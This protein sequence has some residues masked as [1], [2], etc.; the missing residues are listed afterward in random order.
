MKWVDAI[1]WIIA[2]CGWFAAHV[3]SEARERRKDLKAQL[4]KLCDRL[5]SLEASAFSF[6]TKA[7]FDPVQARALIAQL[8]RTER[9]IGLVQILSADALQPHIIAHRRSIT[10]LNFG[11]S[12]NRVGK[13]RW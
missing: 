2:V 5:A 6:H 4:E 12:R 7:E 9:A 13:L 10:L 11:S 3:F 8:D 1:P